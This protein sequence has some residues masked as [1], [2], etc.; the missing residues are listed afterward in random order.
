MHRFVF[1]VFGLVA[2]TALGLTAPGW[3]RGTAPVDF[4][5]P[6]E[7][8]TGATIDLVNHT[9]ATLEVAE[10]DLR[11]RP[12]SAVTAVDT[13]AKDPRLCAAAGSIMPGDTITISLPMLAPGLYQMTGRF[14]LARSD[15]PPLSLEAISSPFRVR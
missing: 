4:R 8:A 14:A 15:L 1:P 11:V 10:C 6:S 3:S 7:I 2:F 13:L 5:V 12:V 9:L